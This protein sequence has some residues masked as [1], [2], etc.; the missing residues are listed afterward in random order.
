MTTSNN[1]P[2]LSNELSLTGSK[3][4]THSL[5]SEH[6][7][8]F[9]TNIARFISYESL[10]KS[11]PENDKH[12]IIDCPIHDFTYYINTII[13]QYITGLAIY[14]DS[15]DINAVANALVINDN[16]LF[17][18]YVEPNIGDKEQ[19][20]SQL[21]TILRSDNVS[22]IELYIRSSSNTNIL[23]DYKYVI[24][25]TDTSIPFWDQTQYKISGFW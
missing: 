5:S 16:I 9:Y 10:I 21:D 15:D 1:L 7:N 17:N 24:C 8:G 22:Q 19:L 20:L 25:S 18:N 14:T 4:T 11:E 12:L 23:G 13:S 3:I 2:V 6:I